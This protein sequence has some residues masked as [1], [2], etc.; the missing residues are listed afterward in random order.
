MARR[1]V[2]RSTVSP[3]I[4]A[5]PRMSRPQD[6]PKRLMA[7]SVR[8]APIRPAMP[9]TSPSATVKDTSRIACRSGSV[10][11]ATHQLDTS[12]RVL[13]IFGVRAG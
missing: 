2:E 8:P 7:S 12:S 10:G 9:T 13:P 5:S 11:W 3:R 6:R 4:R 1:T